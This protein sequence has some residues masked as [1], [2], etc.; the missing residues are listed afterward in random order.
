M[1]EGVGREGGKR[2]GGGKKGRDNREEGVTGGKKAWEK[3]A[4][5]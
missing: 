4:F 5:I 2:G 1:G 3:E